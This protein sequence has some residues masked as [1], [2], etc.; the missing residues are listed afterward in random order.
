M[1]EKTLIFLILRL[2]NMRAALASKGLDYC[3]DKYPDFD[4]FAV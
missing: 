4:T 1:E 3:L 2:S